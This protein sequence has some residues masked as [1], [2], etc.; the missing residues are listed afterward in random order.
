MIDR[1]NCINFV[2]EE[3]GRATCCTCLTF[4][5]L[6]VPRCLLGVVVG[7]A[8]YSGSSLLFSPVAYFLY[9]LSVL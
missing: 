1:P 6:E 8:K 2:E 9:I 3:D 4:Q 5:Q 7:I